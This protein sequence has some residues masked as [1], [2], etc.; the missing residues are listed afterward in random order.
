MTSNSPL[1]AALVTLAIFW[2]SAVPVGLVAVKA[3]A[4]PTYS[5]SPILKLAVLIP[6][7]SPEIITVPVAPFRISSETIPKAGMEAEALLS[8][9]AT[10]V[11][12]VCPET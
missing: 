11:S 10:C 4:V 7:T 1:A 2:M 9:G 12:V 6:D 8:A 5:S 3:P